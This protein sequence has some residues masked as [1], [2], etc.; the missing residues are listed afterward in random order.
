MACGTMPTQTTTRVLEY[1]SSAV[2]KFWT[3]TASAVSSVVGGG[4]ASHAMFCAISFTSAPSTQHRLRRLGHAAHRL[5]ADIIR[6]VIDPVPPT[7]WR[8]TRGGQLKTCHT[9]LK[10]HLARMSIPNDYGPRRWNREWLSLGITQT[11]DH[12]TWAAAIRGVIVAMDTGTTNVC[13]PKLNM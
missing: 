13:S 7:H 3:T 10:E 1:K 12:Q 6:D 2:S 5:T 8:R 9:M 11:Q 4:T